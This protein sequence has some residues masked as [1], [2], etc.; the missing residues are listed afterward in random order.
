MLFRTI[1]YVV[2]ALTVSLAFASPLITNREDDIDTKVLSK[3]GAVLSAQFATESEV[4]CSSFRL[5]LPGRSHMQG[6]SPVTLFV[7]F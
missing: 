3:R 6:Y 7:S 1:S 5:A 4:R 2:L